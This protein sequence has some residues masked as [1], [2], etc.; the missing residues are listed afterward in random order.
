[1]ILLLTVA[2]AGVGWRSLSG[3]SGRVDLANAAQTTA[4]DIAAMALASEQALS[5]DDRKR[6]ATLAGA[7]A[8]VRATLAGFAGR[9]PDGSDAAREAAGIAASLD[10][11]A[12][13][14]EAFGRQRSDKQALQ[15]RHMA[16][17]AEVQEAV[18]AV[19]K[20]QE[21]RLREAGRE[22]ERALADQ[23]SATSTGVVIAY[24]VRS[25]LEM[26]ALQFALQGGEAGVT[27]AQFDAKA[28]S[29]ATLLKRL[30][31]MSA[32]PEALQEAGVALDEYRELMDAPPGD[33]A[34]AGRQAAL[35]ARFGTLTA[36]LR[37]AEQ[38]Q[39]NTQTNAQVKLQEQ[40]DKLATGVTL[41]T[42]AA[43]AVT[44]AKEA[45]GQE[46]LLVLR[47][48]ETGGKGLDAAADGLS[49]NLE[50][51]LYGVNDPATVA[52]LKA[53][54]EKV[55]VFKDSIPEIVRANAEQATILASLDRRAGELVAAARAIGEQ[56]LDRLDAERR[57]AT[58]LLLAGVILACAIGLGLAVAIG[59]GIARPVGRLSDA[60]RALAGG[61]LAASVPALTRR[62]EIGAMART[63]QVFR[64]ALVAKAAADAEAAGEAALKAER[65]A[66]MDALTHGFEAKVVALTE[67]LGRSSSGMETTARTMTAAA[68]QTNGRSVEAAGAAEQTLANVQMVA[69]ASEELSV[70]IGG[71]A[72]QVAESSGIAR[73]AVTKA[74]E[75][76]A[77][78]LRLVSAAEQIGDIVAMIQSIAGQTNLLALNATIE[79]ARAGEA[80]RGFAVVAAEVKGL[81]A[82]TAKATDEISGQ[83]GEIQ[84]TTTGVA[85][86]LREISSVIEQ[87]SGIAEGIA[88]AVEQQ[89]AA[90][91]EIARN[92]NQAAAGT[93]AVSNGIGEVRREA[94]STGRAAAEVLDAAHQ[95]GRCAGELEREVADFLTGVKAA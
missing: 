54:T 36:S 92:V 1:M 17:I 38:S 40:Q 48:D 73:S 52:T 61:D 50:T 89:G 30:G 14:V 85:E 49:E 9:L 78:V 18:A 2:V 34:G 91:Q 93:Q 16:L 35:S 32:A 55:R 26:R 22:L 69:A 42:A 33:D 63:V 15:T 6:D 44:A 71:I 13:E 43:Q 57:S 66:R 75:A 8:R 86:A 60:M 20:G 23:K 70:S 45:Q 90:T 68:D 87:M 41:L 3:F 12:A 51:I 25:A 46:M 10:A 77:T 19:G 4:G 11:F 47:R 5:G 62:D 21:E 94:G 7:V 39:N 80:G 74:Q 28:G 59:R 24:A 95:L 88:T 67:Q 37:K 76:D 56:E 53:L 81:A 29:V 72:T 65:A 64:E 82:Q 27:R 83:I 84:A 58:L 31:A 79:A